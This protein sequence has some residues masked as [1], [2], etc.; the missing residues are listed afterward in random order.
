MNAAG[1]WRGATHEVYHFGGVS[2]VKRRRLR[3]R[4]ARCASTRAIDRTELVDD[5]PG[6]NRARLLARRLRE[7]VSGGTPDRSGLVSHVKR[8]LSREQ[9]ALRALLCLAAGSRGG[10]A[11]NSMAGA[12][13]GGRRHVPEPRHRGRGGWDS[14]AG[15]TPRG[16]DHRGP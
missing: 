12:P 2:S 14:G 4:F 11:P 10:I 15:P 8:V 9:S 5:D 13:A 3:P 1:A 16:G 7:R 6:D